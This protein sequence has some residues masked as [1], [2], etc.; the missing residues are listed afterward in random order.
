MSATQVM[1][2]RSPDTGAPVLSGTAG[3][4]IAV[5]DA[6]LV[7]GYNSKTV[8][9]T[10]TG[11]TATATCAT[12]HGYAADGLTK[13]NHSGAAQ[14]EYNGNFQITNV[15]TLT[16]DFT[17]TGT[18]ATPA[19]GAITA[20]V[21]PLGWDKPYS[22]TNKA[23]YRSP[24]SASTRLYLR[25]RDDNPHADTNKTASL[26]GYETMT[27]VDAGTGL[28]PTAAQLT[29]GIWL[30]K[31][32]TSDSTPHA[33]YMIGDGFEF[34][35]FNEHPINTT[36]V[37]RHFHFGD[38]KSEAPTDPYGCL[39]FGDFGDATTAGGA[40]TNQETF[41]LPLTLT[42]QQGHYMARTYLQTGIS[43]GVAKLGNY[44]LGG[45]LFG[46]N[47]AYLHYPTP[48]S[49][50]LT[51]SP[52]LVIDYPVIRAQL[53]GIYQPL[54]YHPL[55]HGV[56]VPAAKSPVSRRLFSIATAYSGQNPGETHIDIDGPW[57]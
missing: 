35:F 53:K 5:L 52:I 50:S 54:H 47:D 29:T 6:C 36:G 17:V 10:R 12:A 57:R 31:S 37:Y 32:A 20:K 40:E 27:T 21:A 26:Y 46:G 9:I 14:T 13:I 56:V 43:S 51:I 7:N 45:S 34:H 41:M 55:G 44:Q 28:F 49:N 11:S 39:I 4:L 8:T 33:W 15:T 3:A 23:A 30:N 22:G 18:P 1:L 2:L 19:T 42:S 16:Y 24:E 25:V 38:P 48:N